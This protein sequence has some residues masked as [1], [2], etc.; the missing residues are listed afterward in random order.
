MRSWQIFTDGGSRG[1][2][3][4]AAS[5]FVV[6]EQ[7]QVVVERRRFLGTA[8]NN[9][10]EYDGLLSSLDW[11]LNQDLSLIDRIEWKT[12]SLLMANQVNRLWKIKEPRIKERALVIWKKLQTLSCE[13]SL[14]HVPREMN[15]HA[16]SL[17]NQELDAQSL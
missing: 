2:P 1:N 12:D 3:G 4:L 13:H 6:L 16:D 8:T 10:A 15:T 14:S 9:E 11:A 7:N 17:V 5:A